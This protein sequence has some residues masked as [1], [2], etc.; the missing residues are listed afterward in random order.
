MPSTFGHRWLKSAGAAIALAGVAALL[1]GAAAGPTALLT[2]AASVSQASDSQAG[3]LPRC[4]QAHPLDER[5]PVCQRSMAGSATAPRTRDNGRN[6]VIL[7]GGFETQPPWWVAEDA[8]PRAMP[9]PW[10]QALS[11]KRRSPFWLTFAAS[12]RLRL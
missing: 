8:P 6:A 5:S 11:A 2:V 10:H 7:P 4:T 3:A 9:P 12:P 1:L